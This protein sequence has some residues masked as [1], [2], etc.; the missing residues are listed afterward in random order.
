MYGYTDSTPSLISLSEDGKIEVQYL[1]QDTPSDGLAR[2]RTLEPRIM[3]LTLTIR[4]PCP[5]PRDQS[6]RGPRREV[7]ALAKTAPCVWGEGGGLV[8]LV[9]PLV[10]QIQHCPCRALQV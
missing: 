3:S 8:I 7:A 1:S 10:L 5:S 9:R 6:Q 4:P 2:G